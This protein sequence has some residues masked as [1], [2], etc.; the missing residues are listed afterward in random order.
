M[1]LLGYWWVRVWQSRAVWAENESHGGLQLLLIKLQTVC[2]HCVIP[3]SPD[4]LQSSSALAYR[5]TGQGEAKSEGLLW[6][7]SEGWGEERVLSLCSCMSGRV[8]EVGPVPASGTQMAADCHTDTDS[9]TMSL[10]RRIRSNLS[11]LLLLHLL[12]LFI[13]AAAGW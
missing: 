11:T 12:L 10:Q 7:E 6:G 3:P 5:K 4:Q 9:N 8:R 1:R 13:S 2:S